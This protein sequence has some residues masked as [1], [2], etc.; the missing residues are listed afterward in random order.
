M[1]PD[2]TQVNTIFVYLR[3]HKAMCILSQAVYASKTH[4][5]VSLPK[6]YQVLG[7]WTMIDNKKAQEIVLRFLCF[8]S[9]IQ[10]FS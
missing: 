8:I 9:A 4:W 7:F 6:E 2:F 5:F 1:L 10:A 3:L